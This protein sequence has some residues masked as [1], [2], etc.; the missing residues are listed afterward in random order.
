MV[1]TFF[2]YILNFLLGVEAFK[3]DLIAREI[4]HRVNFKENS[5]IFQN[6]LPKRVLGVF[7]STLGMKNETNES[8]M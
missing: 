1:S 5:R 7:A 2:Y 3:I 8:F 6:V 4:N